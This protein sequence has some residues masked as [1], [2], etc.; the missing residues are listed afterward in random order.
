[1]NVNLV[2]WPDDAGRLEQLRA[3]SAPRLLL[4]T[5]GVPPPVPPDC[6]EDWVRVP[7]SDE[8]LQAR[9]STLAARAARHADHPLLDEDGLLHFH[10]AWVS[11]SPVDAALTRALLER[12]GAVV[13]RAA[14]AE[15]AWPDSTPSRNALDVHIL[16]LR[17]RVQPLGLEIKTIRSRGYLLQERRRVMQPTA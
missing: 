13:G 2:T 11:L 15:R 9:V 8:D 6:L 17:R 12:Y 4:L 10:D 7:V 16:R 3:E 5:P 14:L 1:M